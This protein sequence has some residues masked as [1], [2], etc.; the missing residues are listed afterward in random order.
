MSRHGSLMFKVT[1][2]LTLDSQPSTF[3]SMKTALVIV[4]NYLPDIY[5]ANRWMDVLRNGKKRPALL[6]FLWNEP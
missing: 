2:T 4:I 6:L 5:V 1:V 3:V